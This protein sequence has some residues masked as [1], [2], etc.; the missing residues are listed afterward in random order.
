MLPLPEKGFNQP[1]TPMNLNR[2][3]MGDWLEASALFCGAEFSQSDVADILVEQGVI[4]LGDADP[5]EGE[6][7]VANAIA[8]EGW[9]EMRS[10]MD[11]SGGAK[12]FDVAG[13]RITTNGDWRDDPVRAFLVLLSLMPLYPK[14][15]NACREVGQQG[16]LFEAVSAKA[17]ERI[18]EGWQVYH[19]GWSANGPKTVAQIVADLVGL[20][21]VRGNPNLGEWAPK[22]AKDGGLDI[23]CF[24]AFP[25]Q[26]ECVPYF[27]I[28]CA[29]GANWTT[30]LHQPATGKWKTWLDSAFEPTRALMIPFVVDRVEMGQRC[31]EIA[32]PLFDRNRVL[33][34][35]S[36]IENWM[37]D[38]ADDLINWS[39]PRIELL[40]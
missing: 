35:G 31:L 5:T 26:R 18:F 24:R 34:A 16:S 15:A 38:I 40:A 22:A 12:T 1:V 39:R 9:S 29:S 7:D 27:A 4:G 3:I 11:A 32:G 37:A 21:G 2:P 19:A 6:Q 25:D 30:K 23:L 14:W 33:S 36:N 28:Q 13:D 8:E 17:C 20:M 10:R